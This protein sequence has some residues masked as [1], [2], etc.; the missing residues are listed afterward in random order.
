[1]KDRLVEHDVAHGTATSA[2]TSKMTWIKATKMRSGTD[3]L[4]TYRPSSAR[5]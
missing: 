2:N 4:Q 1:M 5:G 3:I